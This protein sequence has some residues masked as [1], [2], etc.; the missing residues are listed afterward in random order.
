MIEG[1]GC[2]VLHIDRVFKLL[3]YEK[4]LGKY[5][6]EDEMK[7]FEKYE[8]NKR[9]YL[10]KIASN[11]CVKEAFFKSISNKIKDF[12]FLDVEV[13][14]NSE[15]KPHINL[16]NGLEFIKKDFKIHVT[17]SNER[18]IVSSFVVVEKII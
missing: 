17:I 15:G 4:F 5:F 18:N 10:K 11:L 3:K 6:T 16:Y 2:D 14:R 9:N 7:F 1:I 8:N 13:L 12:R